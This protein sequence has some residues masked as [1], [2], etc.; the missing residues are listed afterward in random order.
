V[1]CEEKDFIADLYPASQIG[2]NAYKI[3]RKYLILIL[4]STSLILIVL[5]RGF[6]QFSKGKYCS[7]LVMYE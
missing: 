6:P 4:A 3:F 7:G 5:P 1:T 2:G